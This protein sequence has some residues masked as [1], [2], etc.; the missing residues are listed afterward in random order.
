M[1]GLDK[2]VPTS[3]FIG[4]GYKYQATSRIVQQLAPV[5]YRVNAILQH[6][7]PEHYRQANLVKETLKRKYAGFYAMSSVDPLVYEGREILFNRTSGIHT[8]S[9]DPHLGW[10]ILAAFGDFTGGDMDLPN[11]GLRIRFQPGDVIAI[12]GRVIPHRIIGDYQGQRIS[13]PHF[14][15]SATWRAAGNSSVFL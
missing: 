10:A 3:E 12:R 9:G 1:Q 4:A 6:L 5:S 8:D 11:L 15:H 2:I 14:T 13:I 7:D